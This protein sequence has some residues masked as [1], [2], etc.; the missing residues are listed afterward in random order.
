MDGINHFFE[1]RRDAGKKLAELLQQRHFHDPYILAL[2]RG[3]V[4]VADEVAR[5]LEA[6]LDVVISRKIGAPGQPELGIGAISEDGRPAFNPRMTAYF[7]TDSPMVQQTV[8]EESEELKRRK[9]L[10]RHGYELPDLAGKTVIVVDDGLATGATALSA[11]KFLRTKNPEQLILA[12]PIGPKNIDQEVEASF[13]EVICVHALSNLQSVGLW[14][15]D[16]T[17]VEDKEVLSILQKYHS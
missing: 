7:D 2:P 6:Q 4:V 1:D 10:Y 3:G 9:E 8:R 13:D 11:A 14:Y 17:Q 12:V 5:E 16:F 15:N